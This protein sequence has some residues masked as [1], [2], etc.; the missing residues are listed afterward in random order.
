MFDKKLTMPQLKKWMKECPG[1]PPEE[2]EPE[3][4][5][6]FDTFLYP[7]WEKVK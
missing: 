4:P 1:L 5:G 6:V 2:L 3:G 7:K